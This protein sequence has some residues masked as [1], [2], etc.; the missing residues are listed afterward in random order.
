MATHATHK[1]WLRIAA[2]VIGFFGPVLTLATL[3]ATNE[4]ARFGLDVLTW[5]ID[6]FPDY[7]SEEIRFL[8][9]LAGGFLVGWGVTVWM[10]SALVYDLAP[11]AVRRSVVT[12]AWAWFLFDSLGSVTSGQ[13]PNVL[14]NILVLL[15]IVGPMW[16]PAHPSTKAQGNPA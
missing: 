11:E 15:A 4:P 14:W 10:L 7:S 16:R 8:S 1:S 3:P 13:W 6:G 12:G 9:A 2:V 5:P